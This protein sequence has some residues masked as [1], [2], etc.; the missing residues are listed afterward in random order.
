M[1]RQII[2]NFVLWVANNKTMKPT[3][4]VHHTLTVCPLYLKVFLVFHGCFAIVVRKW[5]LYVLTILKV[6][7][8]CLFFSI[9]TFRTCFFCTNL[10]QLFP[11]MSSITFC[12]FESFL[13]IFLKQNNDY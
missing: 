10:E 6:Y 13:N 2:Q 4:L 5:K 12:A 9:K 3:S 11:L 1:G 7:K 8:K